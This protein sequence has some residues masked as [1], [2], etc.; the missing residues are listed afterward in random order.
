MTR[1]HLAVP[2]FWVGI[3]ACLVLGALDAVYQLTCGTALDRI[4]EYVARR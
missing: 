3:T 1:R 2:V 4:A